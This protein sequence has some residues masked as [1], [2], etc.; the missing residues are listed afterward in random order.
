MFYARPTGVITAFG[1]LIGLWYGFK[2]TKKIIIK[3]F[4]SAGPTE[5]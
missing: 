1:S 4:K 2:I 3:V 5:V